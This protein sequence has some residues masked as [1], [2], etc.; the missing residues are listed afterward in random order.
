MPVEKLSLGGKSVILVGTAHVSENSVQEARDE[1]KKNR[2]EAVAV[3]LC[4]QRFKALKDEKG[5]EQT[6]I[7][8][9]ITSDRIYLFLLQILLGN[10]QRKLGDDLGIKPGAEMMAAIDEAESAGAKIILADRDIRLTLKR[11][12]D[13]MTFYEKMRLLSSFIG[14]F[15]DG[16]EIDTELVERLKEK[17]V[18]TELM[19]ELALKTPSIKRVLVD[20]RDEHIANAIFASDA[21]SIVAVVGA[22]HMQGIKK[23]LEEMDGAGVLV[24]YSH[25][26]EDSDI[27]PIMSKAKVSMF[28]WGVPALFIL[29]VGWGL[30]TS[31]AQMTGQMIL[32]WVLV[33]GTLSALGV[34]LAMGHPAS[35][36]AAFLAAP[37]T[38]LNPMVAAGWVA[39]YVELRVR[40]PRVADF[41]NLM[42]LR[43][44]GDYLKNR[45]VRVILIVAFA[46]I[47]STLGTF[48]GFGF[49]ARVADII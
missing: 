44:F 3:E 43:G 41:Q 13:E 31:G 15:I 4:Q 25:S 16:E 19:E 49:M 5:W 33:N 28:A 37:L 18:L 48:I 24:T 34:A 22:G 20:E 26:F 10:F 6:D 17:D 2:P 42:M 35:I 36:A 11:A 46:N 7:G 45:I 32:R 12:M 47:G 39:G 9:V 38:S 29:F 1:I 40:K 23:R 21:K 30:L 27:R 14:G 8:K